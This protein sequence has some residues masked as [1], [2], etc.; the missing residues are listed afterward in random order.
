M[1]IQNDGEI[2]IVGLGRLNTQDAD[3]QIQNIKNIIDMASGV[4][5]AFLPVKKR[6]SSMAEIMVTCLNNRRLTEKTL[7]AITHFK[8]VA[9]LSLSKMWLV[10]DLKDAQKN[11]LNVLTRM[12]GSGRIK[13]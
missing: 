3:A 9:I 1:N 5:D 12:K 4:S 7:I 8:I 13:K 10:V 6:E 2:Q 11:L